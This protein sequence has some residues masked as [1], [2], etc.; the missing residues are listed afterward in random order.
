MNRQTPTP[1]KKKLLR[2]KKFCRLLGSQSVHTRRCGYKPSQLL[3]PSISSSLQKAATL[4]LSA[5]MTFIGSLE[6]AY[7]IYSVFPS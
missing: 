7:E 6:M 5:G 3:L 2:K 1:K 4:V